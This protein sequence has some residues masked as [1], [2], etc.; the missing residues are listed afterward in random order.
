L[1]L[2]YKGVIE[3]FIIESGEHFQEMEHELL[4]LRNG[5]YGLQTIDAIHKAVHAIKN[6]A[7]TINVVPVESFAHIFN[8][9][10]NR[11]RD[12]KV[13]MDA[14]LASLLLDCCYYLKHLV[15]IIV[16][17]SGQLN[18][19]DL[20]RGEYLSKRMSAYLKLEADQRTTL[21]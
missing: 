4:D 21:Q 19:L 8:D 20:S 3:K 10:V 1:N 13:K 11:V 5:Q 6:S 7:G 12:N 2:N 16:K 14:D 9:V 17:K 18:K 15:N